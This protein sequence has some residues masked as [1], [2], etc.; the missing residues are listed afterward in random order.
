MGG[1]FGVRP[2]ALYDLSPSDPVAFDLDCAVFDFGQWFDA[3]RH[4]T[5]RVK[6]PKDD[7]KIEMPMYTPEQLGAFLG[8][9]PM[10]MR[11]GPAPIVVTP[12]VEDWLSGFG[13]DDDAADMDA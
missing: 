5:R 9:V 6:A 8:L 11:L 12:E 7:G 1:H 4:E 3:K 13:E 10:M 2:S